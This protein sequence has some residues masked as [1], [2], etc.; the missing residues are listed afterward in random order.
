[1]LKQA[2]SE[3]TGDAFIFCA[4]IEV[5]SLC[6]HTSNIAY[7]IDEIHMLAQKRNSTIHQT[8]SCIFVHDRVPSQIEYYHDAKRVEPLKTH[9]QEARVTAQMA[10]VP[11]LHQEIAFG[12]T[13]LL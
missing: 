7:M 10:E 6:M 9:N 1:M 4:L 3:A 13:D 2:A 12:G 8:A 11:L 5:S